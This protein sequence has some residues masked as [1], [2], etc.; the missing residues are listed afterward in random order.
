[1]RCWQSLIPA[2]L[3]WRSNRISMIPTGTALSSSG[4]GRGLPSWG[5]PND[6]ARSAHRLYRRGLADLLWA[7]Q[8]EQ[9]EWITYLER[10]NRADKLH[11]TARLARLTHFILPL[12]ENIVEVAAQDATVRRRPGSTVSAAAATLRQ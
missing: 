9:S 2:G 10:Q 1:M 5:P 4:Q 11:D 3:C 6:G 8:V 7:G 12:K